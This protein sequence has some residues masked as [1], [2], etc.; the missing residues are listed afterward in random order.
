MSGLRNADGQ[1]ADSTKDAN[2]AETAARQTSLDTT[3]PHAGRPIPK[4]PVLGWSSLWLGGTGLPSV[5]NLPNLAYTTSGR[6]ALLHALKQLALPPG[7]GVLVPTYHCPTMVAPIIQAG[8]KPL[9]FPIDQEGLPQLDGISATAAAGARAMFVAHYFGVPKSLLAVQTWCRE[10]GIVLVEDCAHSYFGMAGD[11]PVGTWGDYATASL[12]KFFPVAEAGM[13]ASAHRPLQPLGLAPANL[14]TQLKGGF[15]VLEFAHRHGRLLG[16]SQLLGPLFWLKSRRQLGHEAATQPGSSHESVDANAMLASCDMGRVAE[17][18]TLIARALHRILPLGRV[19]E[20]RR[21]HFEAYSDAFGQAWASSRGIRPLA[22]RLPEDAAPYV[23]PLW[24]DNA[25]HADALYMRLRMS[26]FPI[27]RWDRIWP[28]TPT[29]GRDS[30]PIWSRQVLQLLCHQDL[31]LEDLDKIV[32]C[33]RGFT[34]TA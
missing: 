17:A 21:L 27:F 20:R 22:A 7:S 34:H 30:G 25:A 26:G 23:F 4:A 12:S 28:G 11:R 5:A 10:R 32:H 31:T 19:V 18:V 16:P 2:Q 15:S 33:I 8:M 1:A 13:L 6:A 14:H 3:P 29:D 24:L 9:F